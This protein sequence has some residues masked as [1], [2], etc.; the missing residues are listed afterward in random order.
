MPGVKAAGALPSWDLIAMTCQ[1]CGDEASVHVTDQVDGQMRE[2]HLCKP[3]ARKA[4]LQVPRKPPNL[5]LDSVVQSLIVAHVGE[6]VGE[7]AERQCPFCGIKFME[8]RTQGRLGCPHDYEV[9]GRGLWPVLR[10]FHAATRHVGKVPAR[11]GVD[12]LP[13]LRLRAELRDAV[14]RED[15]ETAA[16]LRDQL[17]RDKES[18][19]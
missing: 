18:V 6:L 2:I 7:L 1:S 4:G 19:R 16:E 3:C 8:F 5:G 17:R 10:R 14:A 9:F 12:P 13:L 15:Y 11:R